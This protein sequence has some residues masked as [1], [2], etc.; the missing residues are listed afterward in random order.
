MNSFQQV[1]GRFRSPAT[2]TAD[3]SIFCSTCLKNQSLVARNLA[4]YLPP[5]NDPTYAE[6]ER[7]L[8]EYSQRLEERYPQVC[9]DCSPR[10]TQRLREAGYTAKTDYLRQRLTGTNNSKFAYSRTQRPSLLAYGGW[11]GWCLAF[12][13]QVFWHIAEISTHSSNVLVSIG[14]ESRW[15]A[16]DDQLLA[17]GKAIAIKNTSL[18]A[19]TSASIGI[20]CIWW[21][22]TM[23]HDSHQGTANRWEFYKLQAILMA[24]RIIAIYYLQSESSNSLN[25]SSVAAVHTIVLT[26]D[27]VVSMRY[28]FSKWKLMC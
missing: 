25:A 10:V 14:E 1:R 5:P 20:G 11:V 4:D 13:G 6:Y 12:L 8:P 24:V 22:P 28:L 15:R 27:L 21:N 23:F 16:L 26:F 19:S 18:L 17:L 7:L 9:A 3:G 2:A